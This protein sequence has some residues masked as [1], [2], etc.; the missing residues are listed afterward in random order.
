MPPAPP[1]PAASPPPPPPP[2]TTTK[3]ISLTPLGT[4]QSQVVTVV[5]VKTVIALFEVFGA[6]E[7]EQIA[8]W[9]GA[10]P[11]SVAENRIEIKAEEAH[12]FL[13]SLIKLLI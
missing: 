4:C 5:K 7:G 9:A 12:Q 13:V 3:L 2:P 11:E 6:E 1:P 10:I 8:A